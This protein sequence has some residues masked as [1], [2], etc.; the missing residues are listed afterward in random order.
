MSLSFDSDNEAI[1]P[2]L[3]LSTGG[4]LKTFLLEK[5]R[6]VVQEIA[7]LEARSLGHNPGWDFYLG[8]ASSLR[9]VL[10]AIGLSHEEAKALKK[11]ALAQYQA[12]AQLRTA[13]REAAAPALELKQQPGLSGKAKV[14]DRSKEVTFSGTSVKR[15]RDA[16][17]SGSASVSRRLD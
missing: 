2:Q 12:Q 11:Q 4:E 9:M 16:Y 7:R 8:Q 5:Y 6:A 13:G 15:N 3:A 10:A 17:G 1:H 14:G